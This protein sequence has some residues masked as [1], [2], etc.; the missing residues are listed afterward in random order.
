M[1]RPTDSSAQAPAGP[2][3]T[4]SLR[5]THLRRFAAG[6]A[7]AATLAAALS[8]P[9]QLFAQASGPRFNEEIEVRVVEVEVTVQDLEGRPVQGLKRSDFRLYLEDTPLPIDYFTEL[10]D[11]AAG[12]DSL[13]SAA[14]PASSES[15]ESPLNILV[16]IDE[17]FSLEIDLERVLGALE[18]QIDALETFDRIAIVAWN[19]RRL[20]RLLDWAPP[21]EAA[22][23]AFAAA[24]ERPAWGLLKRVDETGWRGAPVSYAHREGSRE[25]LGGRRPDTD[26]SGPRINSTVGST[27]IGDGVAA[28]LNRVRTLEVVHNN[29]RVARAVAAAI[30]SVS[31]PPVGRRILAL[32]S[33]GTAG[34]LKAWDPLLDVADQLRYVI[35]PVDVPGMSAVTFDFVTSGP[36]IPTPGDHGAAYLDRPVHDTLRYLAERTGGDALIDG[37]RRNLF[38]RVSEEARNYYSL[39]FVVATRRDDLSY[40]VRVEVKSPDLQI[41]ARSHIR[42]LSIASDLDLALEARLLDEASKSRGA[43]LEASLGEQADAGKRRILVPLRFNI[44]ENVDFGTAEEVGAVRRFEL[45]I[46]SLDDFG[47]RVLVGPVLIDSITG[48][49]RAEIPL[50]LRRSAQ[51]LAIS[52]YEAATGNVQFAD[53]IFSPSPTGQRLPPSIPP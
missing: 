36:L 6:F 3:E 11:S 38:A 1:A 46:A 41:R 20:E 8:N 9:A 48:S 37:E 16:F 5:R 24:R 33:G 10:R 31:P 18:R 17:D 32:L 50:R 34:N 2:R 40:S 53:L 52:L 51:R 39:A 12:P 7:P 49:R 30:R 15:E 22:R 14:M 27:S 47:R 23:A 42:D 43:T 4:A 26:F 21:G 28:L 25:E 44:P 13:G 29:D 19:G 35:Y 45:R